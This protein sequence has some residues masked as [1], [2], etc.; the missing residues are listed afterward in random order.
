MSYPLR[1]FFTLFFILF[2]LLSAQKADTVMVPIVFE[3]NRIVST[4]ELEDVI[5]VIKPPAYAFWRDKTAKIDAILRPKLNE[6]YKLFYETEG[7]YDANISTKLSEKG[8]VV[9]IE[10]NQPIIISTVNIDSDFDLSEAI[11]V[12][13]KHRF[14]AKNFS[15]TKKKIN[16][17]LQ[18]HGYCSPELSTKAYIDLE[19]HNADINIILEKRKICHFGKV[20]ILTTSPTMDKNIILSRLHF[21]EGDV[22]D[23]TKIQESYESLYNLEVFDQLTLKYNRNL[24]NKKPVDITYKE[25]QNKI[26][27]RFG[28]GYATDLKFQARAYWEYRNFRGNGK[29]VLFDTLLSDKQK[30]LENRFFVP[31]VMNFG[32]YH[33]D[34]QNAVGYQEEKNIHN[35]DEKVLFERVYLSHTSSEW[36]NSIGLGIEH[37]EIL[38]SA[39]LNDNFFL[40]YPFMRLIY[41][42]RD[43]KLDPKNGLYF[44]HEM[45]YGL[46]YSIDS[47][48]YFKYQEELRLIYTLSGITFSSIGR[49]GAIELFSNNMPESK[50]FFAGGAFTNRAYSYDR[51]G[52]TESSIKDSEAGGFTFANVSL[53]ANFPIYKSFGGAIFTDN[54]M[55]SDNQGIWEFSNHVIT[56]VGIGFRYLTPLGPF[57]IDMGV[58]IHDKNERAVHFQVGQSF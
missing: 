18:T 22:Y 49:L 54:T 58:N 10:E 2:T 37:R 39:V 25:I 57:K 51:I 48:S 33:L 50:K 11:T 36:Y 21:E 14:R 44:S 34:F 12:Q 29:K 53:E 3:G 47:T 38:N 13:E 43:S 56:S 17:L 19:T 27:S 42:K 16:R 30:N 6:T 35:F 45:E 9:T 28:F 26:H 15:E 7:F 40:I 32:N 5:G 4:S 55:I 41:D 8:I 1:R 24:F 46:P 52:I 23:V 31:Y 20:N